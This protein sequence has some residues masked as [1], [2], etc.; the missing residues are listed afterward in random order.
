[1]SVYQNSQAIKQAQFDTKAHP[2]KRTISRTAIYI[3]L[4]LSFWTLYGV[5]INTHNLREFNLQQAGVEA[6]VERGH[7]WVEGSKTPEL[8]VDEHN[9]DA[10]EFN[11]HRYPAKQPGQFLMGALAY[12][13][14]HLAGITYAAQYMLASAWVTFLTASAA[15]ALAV[16][17]VFR[18]VADLLP[19][20]K[21]IGRP[22]AVAV[23]FGIGTT[24]FP[25]SGIAHHDAIASAF[26]IV[27]FWLY[28]RAGHST[29]ASEELGLAG[30]GGLFAGLVVSTSMLPFPMVIAIC[31]YLLS[32]K[33]WKLAVA[34]IIGGLVGLMPLF[35]YDALS[36]GNPLLVPN[37]AGHYSDTY[38]R[39]DL[40]NISSKLGFYGSYLLG[41]CPILFAGLSGLTVL[42][43]QFRREQIALCSIILV[44][45]AYLFS[46]ETVGGCQFGPRYL[47]PVMPF[48]AVGLVGLSYI[49][50]P[51]IRWP[52][53]VVT[54]VLALFSIV[55]STVGAM[56][57]AMYCDLD[58][59]AMTRYLEML[60]RGELR[61]FPLAAWLWIPL[62]LLLL[63]LIVLMFI[64]GRSAHKPSSEIE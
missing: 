7:L 36:F 48:V 2:G 30:A 64:V 14:V 12:F 37:I 51:A 53:T 50:R 26:L 16:V 25:Y 33:R 32:F 17:V 1:V 38:P 9:G 52:Y 56:Y 15:T 22:L 35:V 46:L 59:Y 20:P 13:F 34:M 28:F 21:A 18:C 27:S 42:P 29:S 10:F 4:F 43:K 11:G 62:C 23:I 3:V 44:Q 19:N 45:F 55:V 39:F 40:A 47:L 8:V 41:Y 58:K 57:G 63:A 61:G 54:G 31:L 5:A 60:G 24:A 6:I 49:K